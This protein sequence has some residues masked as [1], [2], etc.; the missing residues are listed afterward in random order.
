MKIETIER[1]TSNASTSTAVDILAPGP[2]V[3]NY[4]YTGNLRIGVAWIFHYHYVDH[5][6][7]LDHRD[8][9]NWY[10]EDAVPYRTIS[11]R[12]EWSDMPGFTKIKLAD[13]QHNL[14]QLKEEGV[15]PYSVCSPYVAAVHA[16]KLGARQINL[17]GVDMGLDYR[18]LS[19]QGKRQAVRDF[20][21][22][23]IAFRVNG[24]HMQVMN[25][26]SILC[27]V[28]DVGVINT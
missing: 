20:A 19:T 23:N 24:V 18:V 2:S 7:L 13:K 1:P 26:N 28:M 17:Y 11:Q 9:N 10:I 27:G 4:V 5:L 8:K 21:A 6:I 25:S 3:K 16:F 12:D 22:L 14:T 15:Y